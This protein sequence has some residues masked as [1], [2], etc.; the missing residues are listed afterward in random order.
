LLEENLNIEIVVVMIP[1]KLWKARYRATVMVL[2]AGNKEWLI[3]RNVENFTLPKGI[4]LG[5]IFHPQS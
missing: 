1:V 3:V 4:A 2:S 5:E